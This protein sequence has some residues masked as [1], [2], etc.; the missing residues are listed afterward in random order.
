M[1]GG[2]LFL[3]HPKLA[4]AKTRSLI[5]FSIAPLRHFSEIQPDCH[6]PIAKSLDH[7]I[8]RFPCASVSTSL[9]ALVTLRS[10]MNS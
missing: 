2:T 3:P 8:T 7:K 9:K 1:I 6:S 4:P 10:Y 5:R